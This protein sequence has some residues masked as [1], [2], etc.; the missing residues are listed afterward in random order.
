MQL[1]SPSSFLDIKLYA[2]LALAI[3]IIIIINAD[4]KNHKGK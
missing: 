4:M 3:I 2:K 1:A